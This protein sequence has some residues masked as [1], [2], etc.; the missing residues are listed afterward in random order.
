MPKV[1]KANPIF[2]LILLVTVSSFGNVGTLKENFKNPPRESSL[3]PFWCWNDTLEKNKLKWQIDQM[4]EKGVYGGFIHARVG[5]NMGKTP[6]FSQGWWDAIETAVN[7]GKET[8]FATWLYDEDRWPSGSAGGR[9]VAVN[10]EEFSQ[11]GLAYSEMRIDGPQKIKIPSS[12][13]LVGV[14]AAKIASKDVIEQK[15]LTDISEYSGK[16]WDVPE[17]K[18]LIMTFRQIRESEGRAGPPQRG[19]DY[20]DKNAVAAFI[21]I[22]HEEYYKRVGKYF[23]N[24]IP[25]IF[26]DEISA[27][28][29][30]AN[31]AWT[32]DFL[33]KFQQLKGYDL[34]KYLPL[35][36]YDGGNITPKIR[37]DYYDIFTTLYYD[38]WFKQIN[39]WCSKHNI[40]LTGHTFEDIFSY[41]SQG[42]YFRTLSAVDIPMTDN[43]DFRYSFPPYIEWFK[44]K[45]LSSI[46]H[47]KGGKLA[48]VEALGGNSWTYN[49]EE[50][51]YGLSMLNVYGI[52]FMVL[53][54]LFYTT[55]TPWTSA[56]F[57]PSWFYQNVYWK[58]FG[59]P[60]KFIQR[61]L[62]MGRQGRHVCDVGI[63]FPI[64]S[65][66][67]SGRCEGGDGREFSLDELNDILLLQYYSVQRELLNNQID[68]DIIDPASI[69]RADISK[70]KIEIAE[71]KYS[72]LI[73]PPLSVINR[74]VLEKIKN[75]YENGGIVIALNTLPTASMEEGKMDSTVIKSVSDIFGFNPLFLRS[76]Y[77]KIDK[78]YSNEF[79]TNVNDKN[80]KAY[81]ARE[82]DRVPSII[83]K[84][85][86][87]DIIIK[88][89]EPA[90][91]HFLHRTTGDYDIY[92]IMNGQKVPRQWT[93]NFRCGG[94][95]EKWHPE[96]TQ[97][98]KIYGLTDGSRTELNLSFQPWEGYYIVF[99]RN[100]NAK[101]SVRLNN[102]NLKNAGITDATE[103]RAKIEGWMPPE[104]EGFYVN[105]VKGYSEEKITRSITKELTTTNPLRQI[106][107]GDKWSFIPVG[108][109]LDYKWQADVQSSEINLPVMEFW[110]ERV[111]DSVKTEDLLL[112]NENVCWKQ[113][114]IKDK[115]NKV[116][117]CGRYLS[118]WDGWWITYSDLKPHWGTIG[119]KEIRF[120]KKIVINEPLK[121]AWLCITADKKY[122]LDING[123][124]AGENDDWKNAETYDIAPYLKTGEN[125]FNVTVENAGALLLQGEITPA[126]SSK[127]RL[128]SNGD[129]EVSNE[130]GMW[131]KAFEYV[132]PP[133]GPWGNIEMSKEPL[134]FPLNVWYRQQLPSGAAGIIVPAIKG[135]YQIFVN[136]KK[137][138]QSS[139]QKQISFKGLLN[140]DKNTLLIKVA[141]K[142]YSE[143]IIEP[144]TVVYEPA[145]VKLSL[146]KDYGLSWYSGRCVYTKEF[147]VP[148]EYLAADT[149]LVLD[150]GEV[151][152]FVE[153][154][155]NGKLA[156]TRV[157]PPFEAEVQNYLKTGKNTINLVVGN[158][159]ANEMKWNIYDQTLTEL[160]SRWGHELCVLRK[161]EALDSGILGP[162]KIVPYKK[163]EVEVITSD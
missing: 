2:V 154:W 51:R 97:T 143:G 108:N 59:Q 117:G 47:L 22:T 124:T 98:E 147:D 9:T 31:F 145:S 131:T 35:L 91:F 111:P 153:I 77:Y 29:P 139:K 58:Y 74:D 81:F 115:Y 14:I 3:L 39:D 57:P 163:A 105:V 6:Y 11:K 20:L 119:G 142:D 62:Y 126:N 120:R 54:G 161:P 60:A 82:V 69:L 102:T 90:G 121:S 135:K 118:S 17:G 68:Y 70:G 144:V 10:P 8:G 7:Y 103:S 23:G 5:L 140:D 87:K 32:D 122:K 158:L 42:D 25:G 99:N 125:I 101:C 66:W 88:K 93:V 18:W 27:K 149:K 48:A 155:I 162:V 33:E 127:I 148:A 85:V 45:Q 100:E 157:W 28:L 138:E 21:N 37:C 134:S 76:G 151:K 104:A 95:V 73:V 50:L 113:I 34:K 52:N 94:T 114:K 146:W 156:D 75:F 83:G 65:Q 92:Y 56:D 78:T 109:I 67:A 24:E 71:E 16:E 150:L 44:P 79:I 61:V 112:P 38:A 55:D 46:V 15:S 86:E 160:H 136:G 53:H 64:T 12:G 110:A 159:K 130:S 43:E 128:I 80:G 116:S 49:L 123:K 26:F 41:V 63:L 19:I 1:N 13:K 36:V 107:L 89:G 129:W 84:S 40:V 106:N 133:L 30:G 132:N 96:T 152:H 72:V 137:V 141:V 4:L